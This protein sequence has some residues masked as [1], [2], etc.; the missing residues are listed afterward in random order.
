[1][2]ESQEIGIGSCIS[3]LLRPVAINGSE[4]C[5]RSA[6]IGTRLIGQMAKFA[7]SKMKLSGINF[8]EFQRAASRYCALTRNSTKKSPLGFRALAPNPKTLVRVGGP[9]ERRNH[10]LNKVLLFNLPILPGELLQKKEVTV[11]WLKDADQW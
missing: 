3:G 11:E 8:L 6:K 2:Q 1:M 10:R 4:I 7:A 5:H 9:E